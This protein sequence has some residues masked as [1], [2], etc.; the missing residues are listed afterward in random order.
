MF[1][2]LT[3]VNLPVPHPCVSDSGQTGPND[4]P[5]GIKPA[6]GCPYFPIVGVTVLKAEES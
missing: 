1:P 3:A 6:L 4:R 2:I 5:E